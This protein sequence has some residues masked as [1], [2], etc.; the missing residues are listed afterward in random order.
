MRSFTN[1]ELPLPAD[2]PTTTAADQ[3]ADEI[4][5]SHI[6]RLRTA[7]GLSLKQ[8]AERTELSVGLVSQIERGISSAS[9]RVLARVA[10]A[11]SVGIGDLF[12]PVSGS[13]SEPASIVARAADRRRIDF[14]STHCVKELLTP[15]EQDPR[16]DIYLITLGQG[17]NSGE[18]AYGHDGEEAGL[19]L[20]GGL[21]LVVE[22][23][24]FVL[25]TGDT[26]RFSSTRPHRFSNAGQRT[27]KLIV[28][29]FRQ[30]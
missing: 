13:Q 12:A 18:E 23:R 9:V 19:V 5:G 25:A 30:P 29:N 8:V 17:G 4:V 16:L 3:P 11:L 1:G 14:K 2:L 6:R 7:R 10:D 24:K 20:E 28:I 26:W 22:D 15:Q 21:E 27:A